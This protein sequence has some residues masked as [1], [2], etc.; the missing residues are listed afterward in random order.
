MSVGSIKPIHCIT[1]QDCKILSEMLEKNPHE[2]LILDCEGK[3][4][5]KSELADAAD[6]ITFTKNKILMDALLELNEAFQIPNCPIEFSLMLFPATTGC[7]HTY[8]FLGIKDALKVKGTCPLCRAETTFVA[9]HALQEFYTTI[10]NHR[11]A[12]KSA[13]VSDLNIP[14]FK[15]SNDEDAVKELIKEIN[16]DIK[17]L[18]NEIKNTKNAAEIVLTN[19]PKLQSLS[20]VEIKKSNYKYENRKSN[21]RRASKEI[22][23]V[24][25]LL[26][27]AGMCAGAIVCLINPLIGIPLVLVSTVLLCSEMLGQRSPSKLAKSWI[28]KKI[29][30]CQAKIDRNNQLFATA[31][32]QKRLDIRTNQLKSVKNNFPVDQQVDKSK[33]VKEVM[34][35]SEE[36]PSNSLPRRKFS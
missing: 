22:E 16:D 20:K 3:T 32:I 28:K 15:D 6:N 9:N 30:T 35:I 2:E 4:Y 7:G 17:T 12:Q 8:N 19:H 18:E 21:W 5:L 10:Y 29:D 34:P 31:K 23:L 24:M 26:Y 1:Y 27:V 33:I 11:E 13:I 14:E 25:T 36:I